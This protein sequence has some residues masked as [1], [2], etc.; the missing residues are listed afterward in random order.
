MDDRFTAE[1]SLT[2]YAPDED[3][4]LKIANRIAQELRQRL[5]VDE[6]GNVEVVDVTADS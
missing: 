5:A 4:A 6:V 1:L 3:E 2:I